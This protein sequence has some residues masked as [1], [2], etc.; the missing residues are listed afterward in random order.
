MPAV[1]QI[2]HYFQDVAYYQR[3]EP[4]GWLIEEQKFWL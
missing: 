3:R 2:L 4:E 1:S